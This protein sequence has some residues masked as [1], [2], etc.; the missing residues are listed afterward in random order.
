MLALRQET[1]RYNL[2]QLPVQIPIFLGTLHK[3]GKKIP[4]CLAAFFL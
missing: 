2:K 4:F 1:C 3:Y